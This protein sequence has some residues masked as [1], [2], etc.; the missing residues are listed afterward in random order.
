MDRRNI[1]LQ[2]AG[3][4]ICLELPAQLLEAM[5]PRWGGFFL[6][7][8]TVPPPAARFVVKELAQ[9]PADA[10]VAETPLLSCCETHLR[11]DQPGVLN[12]EFD[13]ATTRG[14]I[15][16]HRF[17]NDP[18]LGIGP[19]G[20]M[21][22]L[23]PFWSVILARRDGLLLHG[24]GVEVNGLGVAFLGRS[25]AGKST[26]CRS[27][28]P[29]AQLNDEIVAVCD[30]GKTPHLYSTPF[31]GETETRRRQRAA[32]LALICQL[33][34]GSGNRTSPLPA[35]EG[36]R[37]LM[38]TAVI[39]KGDTPTERLVFGQASRLAAKMRLRELEFSLDRAKAQ[40]AVA[41]ALA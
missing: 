39:T 23:V 11:I 31:F 1:G 22:A 12:L 40:A 41:R 25:G 10:L 29:A 5:R 36:L 8:A 19:A 4:T 21:R 2:I 27:F 28:P 17:P 30:V 13:V 35:S 33:R 32:P 3:I 24:S 18:A 37:L 14:N 34:Q 9:P 26:I 38:A 15:T 7:P 16:Y 6:E 20:L